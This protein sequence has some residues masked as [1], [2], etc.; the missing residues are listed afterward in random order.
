MVFMIQHTANGPGVCVFTLIESDGNKWTNG[1]AEGVCVTTTIGSGIEGVTST[2]TGAA[3]RNCGLVLVCPQNDN[4]LFARAHAVAIHDWS[5]PVQMYIHI[6]SQLSFS[7]REQSK[8]KAQL[9]LLY[10]VSYYLPLQ[11]TIFE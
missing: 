8:A 5:I 9:L 1:S 3:S 10:I 7:Y 11:L 4:R 2:T 6:N